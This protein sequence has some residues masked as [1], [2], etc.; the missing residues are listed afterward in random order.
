MASPIAAPVPVKVAILVLPVGV[1][2][3]T[4][5]VAPIVAP[6]VAPR[7]VTTIAVPAPIVRALHDDTAISVVVA[8]IVAAALAPLPVTLELR[9][10]GNHAYRR[11]RTRPAL[12]SV[13]N[14]HPAIV[15]DMGLPVGIAASIAAVPALLHARRLLLLLL[16]GLRV[17]LDLHCGRLR[18][19][20]PAVTATLGTSATILSV[21][22]GPLDRG[23][24]GCRF[25]RGSA[26]AKMTAFMRRILRQTRRKGSRCQQCSNRE[27]LCHDLHSVGRACTI[28]ATFHSTLS[29]SRAERRLARCLIRVKGIS[30]PA[31][32]SAQVRAVPR[33]GDRCR[34]AAQRRSPPRLEQ[35]LLHGE[36]RV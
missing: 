34:A 12:L 25:G 11:H 30:A 15:T 23:T 21:I 8:P 36:S 5:I 6:V 26:F 29:S 1:L 17:L 27:C 20:V 2:V 10:G 16:L 33:R 18:A 13:L 31:A 4:A 19:T 14:A 24:H 35:P 9:L 7:V 32:V 28:V 22:L 3:V